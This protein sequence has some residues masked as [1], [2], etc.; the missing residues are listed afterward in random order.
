[1]PAWQYAQLTVRVQ[2]TAKEGTRTILWHEPGQGAGANL[3]GSDQTVLQLLNRVGADG[4]ELTSHQEHRKG[5]DGHTYW[6]AARCLTIY[7]F[8]RRVPE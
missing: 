3:S 7:T 8:K 5:G 2:S 4:R 6:D 1:M